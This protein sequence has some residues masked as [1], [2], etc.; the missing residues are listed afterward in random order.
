MDIR[1]KI[2]RVIDANLNRAKEAM[3]VL[4]DISRFILSDKINTQ[5]I[6]NLRHCLQDISKSCFNAKDLINC[7]DIKEDVGKTSNI[8]ELE[9]KG[10][11]DIFF[12]NIQRAKE[13]IR[14]LEEFLKLINKKQSSRLKIIRYNI[15]Q[16]EKEL[17]KE[18]K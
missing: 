13:S 4:E 10:I 16:I 6:K 14:V 8:S 3:R 17:F 5:K 15:Y 2:N 11:K 7:R 1:K 12:A 18:I 9:R